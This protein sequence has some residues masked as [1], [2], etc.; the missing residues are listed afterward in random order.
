MSSV[1]DGMLREDSGI[2]LCLFI[3]LFVH[4]LFVYIC[5]LS[6]VC[7]VTSPVLQRFSY[8]IIRVNSLFFCFTFLW[9]LMGFFIVHFLRLIFCITI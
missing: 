6:S 1:C 9:N 3:L 7:V 4:V 5:C 2:C 8:Q